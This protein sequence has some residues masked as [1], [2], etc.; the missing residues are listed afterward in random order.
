MRI[1]SYLLPFLEAIF[2]N[3]KGLNSSFKDTKKFLAEPI[4]NSIQSILYKFL[5]SLIVIAIMITSLVAISSHLGVLL[6]SYEYGSYYYF[7]FYALVL[8]TGSFGLMLLFRKQDNDGDEQ[9]EEVSND[10]DV[11]RIG[12]VFVEGLI[13]G[14]SRPSKKINQNRKSETEKVQQTELRF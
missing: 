3:N 2:F 10:I 13:E 9:T 1:I 7:G 6:L 8:A 5:I 14:F 11:Q 12:L 4:L